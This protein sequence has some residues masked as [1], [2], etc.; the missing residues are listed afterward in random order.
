M[1]VKTR[2]V[3]VSKQLLEDYDI[4]LS[5]RPTSP[6]N[7]CLVASMCK[8]MCPAITDYLFQYETYDRALERTLMQCTTSFSVVDIFELKSHMK[9]KYKRW[10]IRT[11]KGR[12]Q[13]FVETESGTH[14]VYT[15][16]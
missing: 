12:I 1:D 15:K 3:D 2:A 13:S 7:E 9:G 16:E 11:Y 6:C 10:L 8:K 4:D 14:S 5:K